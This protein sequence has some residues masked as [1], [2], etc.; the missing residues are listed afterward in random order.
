MLVTTINCLLVSSTNAVL[1]CMGFGVE[2]PDL[3]PPVAH[4]ALVVAAVV[5]LL[6]YREGI[7]G[8]RRPRLQVQIPIEADPAWKPSK[9]LAPTDR[10]LEVRQ[11]APLRIYWVVTYKA[12]I[13][14]C[15]LTVGSVIRSPA[16]QLQLRSFAVLTLA[17]VG[18]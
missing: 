16:T 13:S 17:P 9:I 18:C 8:G 14:Y 3:T 2:L 5:L 15:K 1:A 4:A 7:I 10:T 11:A 6:R 12:E